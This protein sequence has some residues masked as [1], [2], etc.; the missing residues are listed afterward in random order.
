VLRQLWRLTRPVPAAGPNALTVTIYEHPDGVVH[1]EESGFEGVACIDDAARLLLVLSQVAA[2]SELDWVERWAQG[3]LDFVL[4]MQ[5]PDGTWL[6]FIHDWDGDKNREGITSRPG[7]NF[8]LA[9]GILG[10]QW[11]SLAL[12]DE[13]ARDA[14]K[15]GLAAASAREAPPDV[16]ALHLLAELFGNDIEPS[17]AEKWAGELLACRDGDVLKNAE[18][19]V[20]LPHLWGHVQEG[21]LAEAAR[22]LDRPDYLDAAIASAEIVIVPE[23][24]SAFG[25]REST[26]PYDVAAAIWSLDRLAAATDDDRWS[27]LAAEGRAW[28]DGRNTA[29][30]PVYDRDRGRV[31][32]GIDGTRVSDNSG[33][34]SNIVA[35]EVLIDDAVEVARSMADPFA[36]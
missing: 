28:F 19:E 23:V 13:L 31:A 36:S 33:A 24:T 3:L 21:A 11:A 14:Y 16:R 2:Q 7:Q 32:D 10:T 22:I 17:R 5:E 4:W 25:G 15:R 30:S 29:G 6:N 26:S 18:L 35:A 8:W 34:E 1:A 20:G 9:R 12:G 27:R